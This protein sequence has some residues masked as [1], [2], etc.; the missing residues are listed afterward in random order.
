MERSIDI[1]RKNIQEYT[2][3]SVVILEYPSQRKPVLYCGLFYVI[4][5][6]KQ[7]CNC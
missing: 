1:M 5:I 2:E 7:D 4:G 6:R 3:D